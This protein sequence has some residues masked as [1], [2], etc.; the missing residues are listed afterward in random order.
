MK[1][2]RERF[3]TPAVLIRRLDYGDFDL[4][5]TFLT[6]E[7]GK[8]TVIAK[9]AKRS[10][11]RFSGLLELFYS[12]DIVVDMGRGKGLPVLSEA[13]LRTPVEH[14]GSDILKTAYASY[15]TELI[16]DWVESGQRQNELYALLTFV[17]GELNSGNMPPEV[18]SILFQLRF[19]SL[20]GLCPDL[21]QC[22]ACHLNVEETGRGPLN[23]DLAAGGLVCERCAPYSAGKQCLS[24]GTIK[25]L[26]WM[27]E[28]DMRKAMR[29]RFSPQTLQE[30]LSFLETF[31]PYHLGKESKS[32]RFL[33]KIR[34]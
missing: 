22:S 33:R 12:L 27:N 15:W 7:R 31:V 34:M 3:S 14:I 5:I 1:Q 26:S 11:R 23:I 16:Y 8:L 20:S 30:G 25:Q 10:V 24:K 28:G 32:L 17:L 2:P 6:L 19:L 29:I 18:L 4:I 9:S 13:S 21:N